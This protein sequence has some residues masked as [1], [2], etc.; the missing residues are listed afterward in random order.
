MSTVKSTKVQENGVVIGY[1]VAYQG[2]SHRLVL[3]ET[4]EGGK[5]IKTQQDAESWLV[6]LVDGESLR[7]INRVAESQP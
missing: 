4:Y 5:T 1:D 2:V 6:A 7:R 3:G